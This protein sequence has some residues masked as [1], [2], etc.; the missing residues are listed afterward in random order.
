MRRRHALI[1]STLAV[2]VLLVGCG[3]DDDSSDEGGDTTEETT[4]TAADDATESTE[5]AEATDETIGDSEPE[6]TSIPDPDDTQPDESTP[7]TEDI[8]AFCTAYNAFE[9]TADELPDETIEDIRS[10]A[11]TLRGE[12]EGVREVA[13]AELT[14]AVDTLLDALTQLE[15][16]AAEA[17]TVEEAQESY[18][19]AFGEEDAQNAAEGVDAYFNENCPQADDEQAPAEGE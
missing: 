12:L 11:T 8:E 15:Q 4:T 5:D 1:A 14:D 13:P 6:D 10:G 18:A 9:A 7:P 3:D 19:E 16:I 17:Q 2:A